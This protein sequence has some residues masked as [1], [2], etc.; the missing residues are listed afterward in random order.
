MIIYL[1]SLGE[2]K[3]DCPDNAPH[4]IVITEP[5]TDDIPDELT[6][7]FTVLHRAYTDLVYANKSAE[8]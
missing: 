3:P 5:Y 2:F 8:I 6:G 7:E 4:S 1:K